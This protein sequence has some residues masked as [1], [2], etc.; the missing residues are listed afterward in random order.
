MNDRQVLDTSFLAPTD[1]FILQGVEKGDT[2]GYSVAGAGDVNGDGL[3]DL[4]VGLQQNL[5]PKT[6]ESGEAYIIYGKAGTDGTQFGTAVRV[7]D[8][9]MTLDITASDGVVRQ[10]LDTAS[11]AP[12]DGFNLLG[13]MLGD[14][15]GGSVSGAGDVNGDGF[16]DFIVGANQGD[17]GGRNAGEAYIVY[18]GPHLG[19]VVSHAQTLVGGM[20]PTLAE[21]ATAEAIEAAARAPFLHGG[22][23]N[24]RLEAHADT[25]VLYGGAG[26]DVLELAD[27][28]FR[29]VDGGSGNDRLVLAESLTLDLTDA[30]VRGRVRGIETLSLSDGAEATLDLLSVY[31][32]VE[33]RDNGGTHT[34]P[35]EAFLRLEGVGMVSLSDNASWTVEMNVEGTADLYEQG[36]A[37]LLIDNGL[38]A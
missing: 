35:G 21:D 16:D 3:A 8:D 38:V 33:S 7:D 19:E 11:L 4:I 2:L 9:G 30:S 10:V 17:D 27:D 29:R 24:D 1:G 31:A 32:L 23:G 5:I 20:V 6:G 25:E 18:G 36:A 15:S 28:S 26:D 13:D 12:T 14:E 37:R 22:A 34:S